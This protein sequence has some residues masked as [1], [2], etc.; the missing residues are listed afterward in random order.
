MRAAPTI[1]RVAKDAAPYVPLAVKL[2]E[3]AALQNLNQRQELQNLGFFDDIGHGI[4]QY[5][6]TAGYGIAQAGTVVGNGIAD[7]GPTIDR[8]AGFADQYVV[9]IGFPLGT[10]LQNLAFFDDVGY[11]IS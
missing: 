5:A 6:N 11:G 8:V 2:I 7:N 3:V 4:S 1:E 9:P 10:P